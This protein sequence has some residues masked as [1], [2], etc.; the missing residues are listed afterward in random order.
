M[1]TNK[2]AVP[3]C[4]NSI[5]IK[6]GSSASALETIKNVEEISMSFDKQLSQTRLKFCENV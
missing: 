3:V 4:K 5:K 2:Y 6:A 1:A